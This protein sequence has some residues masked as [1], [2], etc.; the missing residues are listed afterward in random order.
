M[1]SGGSVDGAR[2]SVL[3]SVEAAGAGRVAVPL[4]STSEA[5]FSD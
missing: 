1:G 4:F 3:H 5:R 2:G